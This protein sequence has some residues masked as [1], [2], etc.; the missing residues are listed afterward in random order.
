MQNKIITINNN[1]ENARILSSLSHRFLPI[2]LILSFMVRGAT[3]S[4]D[5]FNEIYNP[6]LSGSAP[7]TF[8]LC[9]LS[10]SAVLWLVYTLMLWVYRFTLGFSIYSYIVPQQAIKDGTKWA[11]V[12]S[13]LVFGAFSILS[14]FFNILVPLL[15]IISLITLFFAFMLFALKSQNKYAE[16]IVGP[17]V[18][19][20]LMMPI[21]IY[22]A[23]VVGFDIVGYFL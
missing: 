12:G 13:N 9:L 6:L 23:L 4:L 2:C 16:P 10:M 5:M 20:G 15:N 11:I 7:L 21:I 19:K 14:I 3:E 22:V 17:F 1:S 18:F 8:V